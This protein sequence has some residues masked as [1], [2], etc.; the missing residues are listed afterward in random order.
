MKNKSKKIKVK[1]KVMK[2][3]IEELD[4]ECHNICNAHA[5][6]SY[7]IIANKGAN[8]LNCKINRKF[9]QITGLDIIEFPEV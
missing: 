5:C 8:C 3:K 4:D 7:K 9:K 1:H 2:K 6:F